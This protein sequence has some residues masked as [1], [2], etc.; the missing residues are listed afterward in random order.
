MDR[1][2]EISLSL[3]GRHSGYV[4]NDNVSGF[5]AKL[6]TKAS[7]DSEIRQDFGNAI[8]QYGYF[9]CIRNHHFR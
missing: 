2:Q 7:A 8:G 3:V 4:S 6:G 9:V 1:P 5:P